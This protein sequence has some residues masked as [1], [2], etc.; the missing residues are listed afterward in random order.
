[1][2]DTTDPT[3][4]R[5][6]DRGWPL[7]SIGL[8]VHDGGALLEH[9][10]ADLRAQDWPNLE[11]IVSDNA[12]NDETPSVIARATAG[13]PR[14]RVHRHEHLLPVIDSFAFVVA[15]ARGEYFMWAAHDDRWPPD[16][17]RRLVEHLEA[18]PTA[19]LASGLSALTGADGEIFATQPKVADLAMADRVARLDAFIRQPEDQGKACIIYG[20]FRR[21][22]LTALDVAAFWRRDGRR[23]DYHLNLAVL[24]TGAL[25]VDPT[26]VHRKR[27]VEEPKATG[28]REKVRT[29]RTALG[30]ISA[31]GGV[32]DELGLPSADRRR[33]Q[34]AIRARRAAVVVD[35]VRRLVSRR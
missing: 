10:I 4:R 9:A 19:V 18:D 7:V 6:P 33:L 11:L 30:W 15:D 31:Y 14:I 32:L 12:S 27:V 28:M 25:V 29:T 23:L 21:E 35:R 5:A 13:D 34:R 22:T 16:Y 3:T 8:P 1:M 26:V 20:V 17:V 2:D 24:G